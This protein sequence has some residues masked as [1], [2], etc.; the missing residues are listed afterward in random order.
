MIMKYLLFS[1]LT[2]M[3]SFPMHGQ[4]IRESVQTM[5][6]GTHS[7]LVL[8]LPQYEE[9]FVYSNWRNFIKSFRGSTKKVRK[10]NEWFI[11]DADIASIGANSVD[12]YFLIEKQ[13]NGCSLIVW[14]DLGGVFLNSDDHPTG[15][16]GA[17]TMLSDF[18][19][20]LRVVSIEG[21]L[22][23]EEKAL[24]QLENDLDKLARLN[25]RYQKEIEEWHQKIKENEV[26][27]AEN[28]REQDSMRAAIE[29]QKQNVRNV[30]Q[31]LTKAKT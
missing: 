18:T 7:C 5:S 8:D 24:K 25:E 14:F 6:L 2:L 19:K 23:G 1:L 3:I 15:F 11:D 30:E 12:M 10:S 4:D 26:K 28:F 27:I 13:R 31:K 20:T 17:R 21:E 29:Q 16:S 9:R 22:S